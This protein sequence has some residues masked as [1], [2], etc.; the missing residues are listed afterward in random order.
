MYMY[1]NAAYNFQAKLIWD[2]F[3]WKSIISF[4]EENANKDTNF[5]VTQYY[6]I[7]FSYADLRN[8]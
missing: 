8:Q 4:N 2:Y 6:S 3:A 5:I 1:N 7:W